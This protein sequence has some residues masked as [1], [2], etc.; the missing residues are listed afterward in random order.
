MRL[1]GQQEWGYSSDTGKGVLAPLPQRFSSS[2][3]DGSRRR[4]SIIIAVASLW[5][6]LFGAITVVSL[7]R[8]DAVE[9][10]QPSVPAV[11]LERPIQTEMTE[12]L[13]PLRDIRE[14]QQLDPSMFTRVWRPKAGLGDDAVRSF[15]E[16]RGKYAKA[17]LRAQMPFSKGVISEQ[18]PLNEVIANIPDG[19][20]AV[21]I[22][23]NATSGV[24]GWAR[25]GANVDVHWITDTAGKRASRVL[26]QN[27]KVLSAER[28]VDPKAE[29]NSPAPTTVTLLVLEKDAQKVSLAQTAGSLVLHLRGANDIKA[30]TATG[31]LTIDDL[32]GREDDPRGAVE[33]VARVKRADGTFE[34]F[35]IVNGRVIAEQAA[36]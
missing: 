18:R 5:A 7:N 20:R 25:P 36:Q 22:N 17:S 21:S 14:D 16:L 13:L 26:V 9:K 31:S 24:E 3:D 11:P 33:G 10:A 8:S 12:V 30:S 6:V 27:A 19:Y 23:V 28:R 34:E 35:S 32:M 2:F 4:K 1:P 15:E 29:A